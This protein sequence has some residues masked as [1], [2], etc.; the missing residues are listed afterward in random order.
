MDI[1]AVSQQSNGAAQAASNKAA[2]SLAGD[3]NQFLTLLTAQ[4]TNQDPLSPLD[5]TQFVEQ[6]ATFAGLEQQ[7]QSNSH[8]EAI[9]EMLQTSL[10]NDSAGLLGQGAM[11]TAIAVEG[12][13]PPVNIFGPE[14]TQGTLVVRDASGNEVYR[15][16]PAVEWSWD[17][18]SNDGAP[19]PAGTYRFEIETENG[20]VEAAV[21]G[22]IDRVITGTDGRAVG[23]G[24]GVTAASY[25]LV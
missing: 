13:V 14:N 6:L 18:T 3:F 19:V 4:V 16:S 24:P 22:T 8:L 10:G 17:G 2:E 5:S 11:A 1:G 7:V 20:S 15:G 9:A 25:T 12:A 21:L 23:L